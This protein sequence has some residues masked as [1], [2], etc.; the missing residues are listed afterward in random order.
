MAFQNEPRHSRAVNTYLLLGRTGDL[1]AVLPFLK[2][3]DGCRLDTVY[4]MSATDKSITMSSG[5]LTV[6]EVTAGATDRGDCFDFFGLEGDEQNQVVLNEE[7]NALIYLRTY[8][9]QIKASEL[10]VT[11]P[12]GYCARLSGHAST[13]IDENHFQKNPNK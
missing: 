10:L 13:D 9:Y 6:T 8:S 1:C 11:T 3:E 12:G 2:K 5:K 4:V 7:A